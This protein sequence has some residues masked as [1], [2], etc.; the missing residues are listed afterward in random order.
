MMHS[1]RNSASAVAAVDQEAS[2]FLER[3]RYEEARLE[4]SLQ[5]GFAGGGSSQRQLG[6]SGAFPPSYTTMSCVAW[7]SLKASAFM[8]LATVLVEL[9][10]RTLLG[11]LNKASSVFLSI[12]WLPLLWVRPGTAAGGGPALEALVVYLLAVLRPS[13]LVHV[14]NDVLMPHTI[15]TLRD[16]IVREGWSILW[17]SLFAPIM[18]QLPRNASGWTAVHV[19]VLQAVHRGTLKLFTSNIQRHLQSSLASIGRKATSFIQVVWRMHRP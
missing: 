1:N 12:A 11:D 15:P 2:D 10:W 18:P 17:K 4:E 13:F 9:D 16:M 5:G 6:P 3:L 8:V 14:W 7:R 19:F